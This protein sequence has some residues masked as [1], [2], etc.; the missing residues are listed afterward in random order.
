MQDLHGVQSTAFEIVDIA[1]EMRAEDTYARDGHTARTLVREADLRIVLMVMK[2]GSIMKEVCSS[3][4]VR[5][6]T[7][8]R[9]R[10]RF[11]RGAAA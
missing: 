8:C 6:H 3:A 10:V 7:A 2:A 11:L 1:R 9:F 4:W 5:P